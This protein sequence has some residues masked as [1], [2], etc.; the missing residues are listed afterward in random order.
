MTRVLFDLQQLMDGAS[1]YVFGN[2]AGALV[3]DHAAKPDIVIER[4]IARTPIA[5]N[6]N[7]KI[8]FVK[9]VPANNIELG[10]SRHKIWF[11]DGYILHKNETIFDDATI[12]AMKAEMERALNVY[13]ATAST[14]SYLFTQSKGYN[15]DP[16]NA[17]YDFTIE[18]TQYGVS[19]TT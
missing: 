6:V 15:E 17:M 4:T 11:A 2:V 18:I 7:G 8:V 1:G 19:A 5:N 9:A 12:M 3:E 16:S 10:P 13:N 14:Y